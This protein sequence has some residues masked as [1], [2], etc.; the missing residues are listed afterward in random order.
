M[1]IIE[2]LDLGNT[3]GAETP[4]QEQATGVV[5]DVLASLPDT[6]VAK[7]ALTA[8]RNGS[9]SYRAVV[10]VA[11]FT[12]T[13]PTL[14]GKPELLTRTLTM[15]L[16]D[17]YWYENGFIIN[18]NPRHSGDPA[19]SLDRPFHDQ[20]NFPMPNTPEIDEQNIFVAA[21][22]SM[23]VEIKRDGLYVTGEQ[24][25]SFEPALDGEEFQLDRLGRAILVMLPVEYHRAKIAVEG[26]WEQM[27]KDG[28]YRLADGRFQVNE[29][30]PYNRYVAMMDRA[31]ASGFMVTGKAIMAAM[32]ISRH[33]VRSDSDYLFGDLG[34]LRNTMG[35]MLAN[36]V[37][38]VGDNISVAVRHPLTKEQT[39]VLI[40]PEL[41]L[42][43]AMRDHNTQVHHLNKLEAISGVDE[44]VLK[45]LGED[46][47]TREYPVKKESHANGGL[48]DFLS[49]M[50]SR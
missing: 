31:I 41:Y 23:G 33:A 37:H 5:E 26:L 36:H 47:L 28:Y 4:D 40:T 10:E 9:M 48:G 45:M 8:Y 21:C 42:A 35:Q 17:D 19:V 34:D 50:L 20:L 15:M 11:Q 29:A 43:H 12:V 2:S 46:A 25:V 14:V 18:R 27:I 13:T 44:V 1:S 16:D 30:H 38:L 32:S 24:V 3:D 7:A 6:P 22:V 49:Q 39:P